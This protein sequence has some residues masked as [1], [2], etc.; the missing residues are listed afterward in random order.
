MITLLK[1]IFAPH[2]AW[3]PFATRSYI[4][5]QVEAALPMLPKFLQDLIAKKGAAAALQY[6]ADVT[7]QCVASAYAGG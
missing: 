5:A 2:T 3:S 6:T 7:K 4:Y 1:A